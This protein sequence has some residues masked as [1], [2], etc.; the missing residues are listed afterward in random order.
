MAPTFQDTLLL[1][2]HHVPHA[3]SIFRALTHLP[4]K[5][6]CE[7]CDG[8]DEVVSKALLVGK[9]DLRLGGAAPDLVGV[10]SQP[11]CTLLAATE[12]S[13]LLFM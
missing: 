9:L 8:G 6:L 2:P 10:S 7:E 4:S 11:P 13:A 12:P 3:G 1:S 5:W